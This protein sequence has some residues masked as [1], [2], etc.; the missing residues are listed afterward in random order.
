MPAPTR[1]LILLRWQ[2]D[3][4]TH[5]LVP[6]RDSVLRDWPQGLMRLQRFTGTLP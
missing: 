4:Q 3:G 1:V 6:H 2:N 5:W